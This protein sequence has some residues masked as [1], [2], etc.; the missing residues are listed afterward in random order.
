MYI[1]VIGCQSDYLSHRYPL[2]YTALMT[3]PN[4]PTILPPNTTFPIPCSQDPTTV[5]LPTQQRLDAMCMQYTFWQIAQAWQEA[6]GVD[7]VC[8]MALVTVKLLKEN[9]DLLGLP[10]AHKDSNKKEYYVLPID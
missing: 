1:N 6:K 5:A 8:K 2:W 7:D 9:R 3:D 4:T 10:N